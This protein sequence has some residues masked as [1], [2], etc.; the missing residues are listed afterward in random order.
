NGVRR[1][2]FRPGARAESLHLPYVANVVGVSADAESD[3]TVLS[4]TSSLRPPA[5]LG[6]DVK[7]GAITDT[8]LQPTGRA[9]R[10]DDLVDEEVR[11]RSWD[12]TLVP[13]SIIH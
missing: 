5:Y 10:P 13:L 6:V 7:T 8:E 11:V 9:G 2:R 1:L 12:G 4:A 3:A